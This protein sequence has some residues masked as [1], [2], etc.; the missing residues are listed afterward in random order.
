MTPERGSRYSRHAATLRRLYLY[1]VSLICLIVLQNHFLALAGDLATFWG[2]QEGQFLVP[3]YEHINRRML[4]KGSFLLAAALFLVVHY[5]LIL[6]WVRRDPRE[7]NSPLRKLFLLASTGAAL[8]YCGSLVASLLSLLLDQLWGASPV[9]A[10]FLWI[11]VMALA[12]SLGLSATFL[13]QSSSMLYAERGFGSPR[14]RCQA[15]EAIFFALV[16][17]VAL[18]MLMTVSQTGLLYVLT[19]PLLNATALPIVSSSTPEVSVAFSAFLTL[20]LV[21][22][23][24]NGLR[25]RLRQDQPHLWDKVLHT[26]Y[27]YGGQLTGLFILLS[28]LLL[29]LQ[30]LLG[31]FDENSFKAFELWPQLASAV[32]GIASV[33]AGFLWWFQRKISG[34]PEATGL[35]RWHSVPRQL[36]LYCGIGIALYWAAHGSYEVVKFFLNNGPF[37][38]TA[39]VTTEGTVAAKQVSG[40][41]WASTSTVLMGIPVLWLLWRQVRQQGL[42]SVP[43][44]SRYLHLLPRRLYLYGV[45]IFSTLTLLFVTGRV[46]Q[47]SLERLLGWQSLGFFSAGQFS[48]E[49]SLL[50]ILSVILVVHVRLL[51]Q[52]WGASLTAQA[53]T[54][55]AIIILRQEIATAYEQQQQVT[56]HIDSLEQRLSELLADDSLEGREL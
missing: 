17:T 10:S 52:P 26:T 3:T 4:E 38:T 35:G 16:C 6:G 7:L 37:F 40:F 21:L 43:S 5:G 2:T 19:P 27:L 8:V 33:G 1:L 9:S 39:S 54:E 32:G 34:A 24:V 45:T 29:A 53:Q 28:G 47:A 56:D 14:A 42:A 20:V 22:H 51:R 48:H 49:A 12:L 23:Q 46:I 25:I 13:I 18:L 30:I 41:E 55:E 36:Y 44:E 15:I 11:R 50:A 31:Q